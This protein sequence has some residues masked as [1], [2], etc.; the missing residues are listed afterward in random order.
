MLFNH[1]QNNVFEIPLTEIFRDFV[2]ALCIITKNG[3]VQQTNTAYKNLFGEADSAALKFHE[4]FFTDYQ[5][6][7]STFLFKCFS[8]EFKEQRFENEFVLKNGRKIWLELTP[9]L[10]VNIP[11]SKY[12]FLIIRDITK[13]KQ[14]EY[15]LLQSETRY[16]NV[17]N[18]ANDAM[19]VS[20]LN[21]GRTLS[22]FVDVNDVACRLLEYKKEELITQNPLTVLFNNFEGEAAKIT[23]KICSEGHSI[24]DSLQLSKSNKI[25]PAEVSAHL[26]EY[27][28]K[29]GVL[30]ISRDVT[31]RKEAERKVRETGERLRSLALHLQNIREEERTLIA[32]EIHDELG[33]ILTYIKIQMNLVGKKIGDDQ[34]LL[35]EKINSSL[36]LIDDA[37]NSIQKIS[38]QL[39]PNVLDELGIGAAIE[40]Q[41][42]EF[43]SLTNI[44]CI[45]DLSRDEIKLDK[46]KSTAIFRIFQEALTN[47]A[48]HANASKIF[49]SLTEFKNNLI[50]EIKDNGKGITQSQ[51]D[52]SKSLGILGMK[53]RAMLFGGS[54]II[55]SSMN[56]GT[57]V[58]VELPITNLL[59]S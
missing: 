24:F 22:N 8:G 2:D 4:N 47:V 7:I 38:A 40:W 43:A 26:I 35:K 49:V 48:R 1:K 57:T 10:P 59:S 45:C 30:F 32:Q 17:F 29:P 58:R 33:Q 55:K 46:Q 19:F 54:V 14:I 27:N 34:Q 56:S 41:A 18:Q 23:D 25:I 12:L 39:R 13:E 6:E 51:I 3:D 20:Y 16:R 50:L 31:Q 52:D 21:Y 53:E 9:I 15:K 28:D 44:D 42:K 11:N 5:K 37:I 36:K